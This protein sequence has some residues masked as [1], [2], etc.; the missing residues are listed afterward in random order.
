MP[1]LCDMLAAWQDAAR[2]ERNQLPVVRASLTKEE[3]RAI[4]QVHRSRALTYEAYIT[5]VAQ[6]LHDQEVAA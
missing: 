1:T 4:E 5:A 6:A 3:R 2:F